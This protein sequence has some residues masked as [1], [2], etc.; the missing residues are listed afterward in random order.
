MSS[1]TEVTAGAEVPRLRREILDHFATSSGPQA[2]LCIADALKQDLLS[3]VYFH[4][5]VLREE[6]VIAFAEGSREFHVLAEDDLTA[7]MAAVEPFTVDGGVGCGTE[8][9]DHLCET[10]ERIAAKQRQVQ[11][12]G[13]ES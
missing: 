7:L 6:G 8:E 2:A 3:G 5:R 1:S 4:L 12:D 11:R 10:Y 13:G 9:I